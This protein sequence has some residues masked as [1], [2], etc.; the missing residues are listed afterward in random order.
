MPIRCSAI[1][2]FV[3]TGSTAIASDGYA[4]ATENIDLRHAAVDSGTAI[5]WLGDVRVRATATDTG[6][7]FVG[8][9]RTADAAAY[10]RGVDHTSLINLGDDRSRSSG[11]GAPAVLPADAGIWTV[12]TAGPG[13]QTIVWP[14]QDGA[15]TVVVM[16]ADASAPVDVR[17]EIGATIPSLPWVGSGVILLGL[18]VLVGGATLLAIPIGRVAGQRSGGTG[19]DR[20]DDLLMHS[21]SSRRT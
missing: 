20:D 21:G 11:G 19:L 1:D 8:I 4:I 14:A 3:S 7:V 9:A 2:G 16:N 12:Q 18:L 6:S 5:A 17:A 13:T 10:L 15:W